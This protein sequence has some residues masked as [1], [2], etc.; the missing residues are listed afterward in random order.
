MS[1][2]RKLEVISPNVLSSLSSLE[3]PSLY[4]SFVRWE[5]EGIE[6]PGSSASLAELQH[7]S[8]LTTLEVRVPDVQ[9]MP[10]DDLFL[11]NMER[12]KISVEHYSYPCPKWMETSNGIEDVREMRSTTEGFPPLKHLKLYNVSDIKVVINSRMLVS[13]LETLSL[14]Y[15]MNLETICEGQLKA[16]CFGRLR[17]LTVGEC[18][19][20]KN[21]LSLS[22]AKGLRQLE[23]IFVLLMQEHERNN[24]RRVRDQ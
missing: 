3:E 6:N 8:R 22:I 1:G 14:Y 23:E 20:L 12:Y 11:G 5:V 21:L 7:L 2:C 17:F 10:Q 24:S 19:R 16:E 13:C 18:K 15:S 4:D 9:T